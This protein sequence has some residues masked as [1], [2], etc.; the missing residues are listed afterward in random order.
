M[1]VRISSNIVNYLPYKI[2]DV[3]SSSMREASDLMLYGYT[4]RDGVHT[5]EE[6]HRILA[7]IIDSGFISKY[8]IIRDLEFKANYNGKKPG[9]EFARAKWEDDI[10]FVS[11]YIEGNSRQIDATFI[12]KN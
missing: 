5:R 11:E 7:W 6:R 9:N 3:D 8:D 2:I 12:R 1:Y 4:V 10:E